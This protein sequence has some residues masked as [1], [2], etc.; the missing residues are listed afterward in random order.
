MSNY[1]VLSFPAYYAPPSG[2]EPKLTGPEPVVLPITPW[3]ITC[4]LCLRF[5][6]CVRAKF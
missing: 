6:F 4:K 3:G 2:L 5:A 1:F